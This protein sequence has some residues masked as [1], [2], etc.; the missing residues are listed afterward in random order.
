MKICFFCDTVIRE[1]AEVRQI[2]G[3]SKQ[4]NMDFFKGMESETGIQVFI[5]IKHCLTFQREM[6]LIENENFKISVGK[7]CLLSRRNPLLCHDS[8]EVKLD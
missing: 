4:Y 2:S 5:F 6:R 1:E 7:Y 3:I 8:P